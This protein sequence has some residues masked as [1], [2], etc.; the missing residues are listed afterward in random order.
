MSEEI[1]QAIS[2]MQ[3]SVDRLIDGLLDIYKDHPEEV[4][5]LLKTASKKKAEYEELKKRA[6]DQLAQ[7]CY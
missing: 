5:K 2:D 1:F 7:H 3:A 4:T 6:E